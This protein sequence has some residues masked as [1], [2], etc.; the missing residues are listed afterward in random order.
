MARMT[1]GSARRLVG[2][3][4]LV[5]ALGV[6]GAESAAAAQAPKPAV[7]AVT[8]SPSRVGPHGGSVVVRVRVA[9]ALRCAFRGQHVAFAAAKL[10]RTVG[11]AS[12]RASLR[13]PIAANKYRR[14]VTL[15]FSVTAIGA[16]SR[17]SYRSVQVVQAAKPAP[18]KPV[19]PIEVT[20]TTVPNAVFN[21]PYTLT[22]AATGGTG[23]YSWSLA[24]GTLPP[25]I[26]LSGGGTL[27]GTPTGLGQF[28]FTV[29][30]ADAAGHSG[31]VALAIA[32]ADSRVPAAP[33]APTE[34]SSNWSGY[35]VAGGPFTS[36]GGTFNVPTVTGNGA[37][38]SAAEWVGIDGWG[39][40]AASIIQAGVD[41]DYSSAPNVSEVTAWYE[42]YPA[43]AE[44]V[45]L[46]VSPDDRVTVSIAEVSAGL[47]NILVADNTTSQSYNAEFSYVGAAST[48]EWIVEAPFSTI[49]NSVVPLVP[50]TPVTFTQLAATPT[51]APPTRF[52]MFQSGQQVSTPS[53]LSDNGF[54][55]GYGGVTPGA[56]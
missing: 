55:V 40:G 38:A 9:H 29:R 7:K 1:G 42:L 35:G 53:P 56:P 27:S 43:P 54:T 39:P 21:L 6:S 52:V 5:L 34:N 26:T 3:A 8:A 44:P 18:P 2:V 12:G 24:S 17:S 49:T 41:E 48:A 28:A 36:V 47:W 14:A 32:V 51:G 11:C 30:A 13:V 10:L 16:Q 46:T 25:G 15:H 23:A 50:F 22:L 31:T 33:A 45:P 19:P 37:D 4:L 20:T